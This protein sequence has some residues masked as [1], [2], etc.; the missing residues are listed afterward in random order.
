VPDAEIEAIRQILA[1]NPRPAELNE[2]REG[3][4]DLGGQYPLPTDVRVE[5]ANANGVA[6]EWTLTPEADPARAIPYLHGGGYISG[7]LTGHRHMMAHAGRR[8]L[9]EAG[10]FIRFHCG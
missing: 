1:A 4:D 5:T 6:A 7:S 8:A 9:V 2:R 3:L 10:A